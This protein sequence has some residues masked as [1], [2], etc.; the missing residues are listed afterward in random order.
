V[1]DV[2]SLLQ[3]GDL[4]LHLRL[5]PAQDLETLGLVTGALEHQLCVAADLGQRHP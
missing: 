3:V 1:D 4:L 2:E 5:V